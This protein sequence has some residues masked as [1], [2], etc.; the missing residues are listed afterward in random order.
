[1]IR[2]NPFPQAG[3]GWCVAGLTA[4]RP[5]LEAVGPGLDEAR[6]GTARSRLEQLVH[7]LAAVRG[8]PVAAVTRQWFRRY[9]AEVVA[10]VLWLDG[11]AGIALEAHQQNTLVVLDEQGW[12][13]GGRYRDNQ[14]YYYRESHRAELTGRLP[15]LSEYS[16]TF[17][18]DAVADERFAYYLALNNICGL[19]GA[20]GA[21]RLA[22]EPELLADLREFLHTAA[23]TE[24]SR[25]PGQL[26]AA[27][28]LRC[29]GNLLTRLNGMDEL[30]GP[31]ADQSVYVSVR[32]PI[33][34]AEAEPAS[35]GGEL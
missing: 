24:P 13:I 29:K 30:V 17:V 8:E 21:Q 32:N 31:V 16:D 11:A 26:L 28:R 19:V 9:L 33:R 6:A 34:R 22:P 1:M 25:L 7:R 4:R 5:V 20:I 14:G 27:P 15:G 18:P 3:A 23:G 35:D 2:Q 10:P 12:P